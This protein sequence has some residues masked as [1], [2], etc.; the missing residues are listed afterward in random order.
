MGKRDGVR[1]KDRKVL[2]VVSCTDEA[3]MNPL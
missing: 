2:M 1:R 3:A